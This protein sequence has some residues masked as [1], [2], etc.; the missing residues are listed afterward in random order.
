MRRRTRRRLQVLGA[1]AIAGVLFYAAAPY[2]IAASVPHLPGVRPLLKGYLDNAIRTW[3]LGMERPEGIDLSDPSLIA[4]GAGHFET[5]C[6]PCHGAPGRARS[7]VVL[8]MRPAPPDLKDRI[9]RYADRELAWIAE[10]GLKYSGMPAWPATGR[11][12][13]PWAMAAFLR[14]YPD[15]DGP[16]YRALAFGPSMPPGSLGRSRS[17]AFG[18]L[19][20]AFDETLADCA[21]C[22]G[23][24]GL[25]RGG[26]APRLAGQSEAYLAAVLAAYATGARPSGFMQPVAAALA[27]AEIDRLAAHYA[28]LPAPGEAHLSMADGEGETAAADDTLL[29]EG[30]RIAVTGDPDRDVPAC[31]ACHGPG[32]AADRRPAYPHIAGQHRAFLTTWLTLWRERPLGDGPYAAVM[33]EAAFSLTDRQI[34]ALSAWYAAGAPAVAGGVA[35][36]EEP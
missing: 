6:A 33:H 9:P 14:R 15:L 27:P 17:I 22:H 5:G 20:P 11:P 24:D 26:V 1:L 2:N 23:D 35:A 8:G 25:G 30:A 4:R 13:E 28:G 19:T 12:R 31:V 3:S 34:R 16:A 10:N 29:A 7:P 18:R 32:P 21:R 36:R